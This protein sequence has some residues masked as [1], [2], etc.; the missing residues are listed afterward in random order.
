M[1]NQINALAER[2]KDIDEPK[3]NQTIKKNCKGCKYNSKNNP[4]KINCLSYRQKMGIYKDCGFDNSEWSPI[5][6]KSDQKNKRD[7]HN[8]K[9]CSINNPYKIHCINYRKKLGI[10]KPCKV[11]ESQWSPIEPKSD[12]TIEKNCNNCKYF[13][14]NNPDKIACENYRKKLGIK[15]C[16]YGLEW[17]PIETKP[18]KPKKY[19]KGDKCINHDDC[20]S[21]LNYIKSYITGK[22]HHCRAKEKGLSYYNTCYK[23]GEVFD[24]HIKRQNCKC[25]TLKPKTIKN[26]NGIEF[27]LICESCKYWNTD[28]Y[29]QDQH[30][31]CHYRKHA[32]LSNKPC[33]ETNCYKNNMIMTKQCDC[34]KKDD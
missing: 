28:V 17:S 1:Q 13:F 7:C 5:K 18:I 16:K 27:P 6:P 9:Y 3:L 19:S 20:G 26:K 8:C 22:C 10:Y 12:Q 24:T 14:I 23:C 25:L 21:Y 33:Y 31:I 30:N 34:F 4:D 15:N 11:D 29:C 32:F 2:I